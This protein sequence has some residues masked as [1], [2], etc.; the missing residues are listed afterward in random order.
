VRLR[1]LLDLELNESVL[2]SEDLQSVVA[3]FRVPFNST[4]S[5]RASISRE[6]FPSTVFI[7]P[8]DDLVVTDDCFE[9][10]DVRVDDISL[11]ASLKEV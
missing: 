7:L 3:P 10:T 5:A 4:S 6:Y 11:N 1:V 2:R 8:C 9:K